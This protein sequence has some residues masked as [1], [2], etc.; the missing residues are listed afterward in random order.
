[1]TEI[2]PAMISVRDVTL[3]TLDEKMRVDNA[4]RIKYASKYA[5]ISNAWKKWQG[6]IEGLKNPM[7]LA[8]SNSMSKCLL[9]KIR[10]SKQLLTTSTGFIRSRHLMH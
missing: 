4:T 3:K 7:P 5:R 6:E 2:D 9:L 1:M 10:Q 8:K